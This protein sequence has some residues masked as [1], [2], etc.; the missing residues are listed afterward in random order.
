MKLIQLIKSL[1]SSSP[2]INYKQLVVDGA[3][4]LDVRTKEEYNNAHSK[5]S[6]NIP[7]ND[8]PH[9]VKNLDTSKT[10]LTCCVSGMRSAK[11]KIILHDNG[12]V[13]V[14]NAGGWQ[15]VNFQ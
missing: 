9:K 2:I 8:L 7:L 6:V 12:F 13:N 3:I 1:F 10:Y 5:H 15:N 14:H 11:A 4:V